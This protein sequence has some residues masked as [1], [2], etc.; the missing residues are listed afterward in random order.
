MVMIEITG[1]GSDLLGRRQPRKEFANEDFPVPEAPKTTILVRSFKFYLVLDLD[2]N[3][4][5]EEELLRETELI[6]F[7]GKTHGR[8]DTPRGYMLFAINF[9]KDIRDLNFDF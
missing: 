7:R 9:C 4:L 8:P 5:I 3:F 2:F 6:T 1:N